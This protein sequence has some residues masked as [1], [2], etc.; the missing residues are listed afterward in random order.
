MTELLEPY[1]AINRIRMYILNTNNN[2]CEL[3]N[4]SFAS[5]LENSWPECTQ[6]LHWAYIEQ[7]IGTWATVSLA[8]RLLI[9]WQHTY[10]AIYLCVLIDWLIDWL[11]D[12][13]RAATVNIVVDGHWL[14]IIALNAW[15]QSIFTG[16]G[17]GQW[18]SRSSEGGV[19]GGP[20]W[21]SPPKV[22]VEIL[23]ATVHF[24]AF[25]S[26]LSNF[27]GAKRYSRPGIFNVFAIW[28]Q[29]L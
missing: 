2:L 24:G 5:D 19:Y 1:L 4:P 14:C 16:K 27:V 11:M 28:H 18:R 22:Y 17:V 26:R 15:C 23:H 3:L 20:V 13:E 10:D 8:G 9:R 29:C 6:S 25:W 12:N 7:G 21:G